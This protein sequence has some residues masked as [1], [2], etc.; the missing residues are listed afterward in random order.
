MTLALI[1]LGH[2]TLQT[3][4]ILHPQTAVGQ[5]REFGKLL[6]IVKMRALVSIFYLYTI[7]YLKGLTYECSAGWPGVHGDSPASAPL[8]LGL[9]FPAFKVLSYYTFF[10]YVFV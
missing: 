2:S 4:Q 9:S 3:I 6:R 7:F 1:T 5:S 8:A 10:L